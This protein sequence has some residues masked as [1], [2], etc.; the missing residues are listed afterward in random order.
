MLEAPVGHQRDE[1]R[2]VQGV[3][4]AAV[5]SQPDGADG[6]SHHR[7]VAIVEKLNHHIAGRWVSH[8]A[9]RA[10]GFR[11]HLRVVVGDQP[12]EHLLGTPNSLR[13]AADEE[14]CHRRGPGI[15]V[16]VIEM[17]QRQLRGMLAAQHR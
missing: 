13:V 15:E 4:S 3:G 11:P 1:N 16:V 9:K 17:I 14:A 10:G 7:E 2:R 12:G 6:R 5:E 8:L